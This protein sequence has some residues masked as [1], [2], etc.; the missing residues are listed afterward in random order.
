MRKCV[1]IICVLAICGCSCSSGE[2]QVKK[3]KCQQVCDSISKAQTK[4]FVV[5]KVQN[6]VWVKK[7]SSMMIVGKT[8][9]RRRRNREV[10]GSILFMD[11]GQKIKTTY[12]NVPVGTLL[13]Q[14]PIYAPRRSE[15]DYQ[16]KLVKYR[17]ILYV[18]GKEYKLDKFEF[19]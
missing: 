15:G 7:R 8:P 12:I 13:I 1:F 5:E 10:N 16:P 2:M 14:S 18:D 3:E 4:T 11:N 17:H 9:I 6:A 19:M